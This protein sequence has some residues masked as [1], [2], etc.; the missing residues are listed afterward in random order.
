MRL[1]TRITLDVVFIAIASLTAAFGALAV[2]GRWHLQG[3]TTYALAALV[4]LPIV[5][6]AVHDLVSRISELHAVLGNALSAFRDGDFGLRL[7]VRGDRELAELKAMYNALADTVRN[8]REGLH[9]K[10]VLLD[11]ILQRTPVA[12]V[13]LNAADRVV[14][15]N[16]AA[17]ELLA[18]GARLNDRV[19]TDLPLAPA[20]REALVSERD[21]I[22]RS[23]E[24]VFHIGQRL[25]HLNTQRHRLILVERLTPQLRRQEIA[26][27]KKAIRIMNH[28]INNSVA[29]ISSLFHSARRAQEQ[30]EHRHRVDEIYG[31]IEE[32][33]AFL[34]TFLGAYAE[35]A[36]LPEPHKKKSSWTEVIQS[37]QLLYPCLLYTSPSPRD[38]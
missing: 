2:G 26:V 6:W 1:A 35:F 27:W 12:V 25:F 16:T 28:E 11:T 8:N 37:A 38:A 19:L 13:L 32:R 17:R 20:L 33:L 23:D 14:Y 36:R 22:F 7:A 15:S 29:P 4:V 24:E 9:Q 3:A 18:D 21:A 34:R 30:P 5:L 10:E 31:L